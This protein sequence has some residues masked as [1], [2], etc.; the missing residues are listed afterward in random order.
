M[1]EVQ[2]PEAI[3]RRLAKLYGHELPDGPPTYPSGVAIAGRLRLLSGDTDAL[4][5]EAESISKLVMPFIANPSIIPD[6]APCLATGCFALD[7]VSATG[8][9]RVIDFAR[10][11]ADRFIADPDVR[12]ED[13]YFA[14]SLLGQA[15]TMTGESRY[16]DALMDLLLSA[17]T[18]QP[19]GLYWHCH[20][21]PWFWGR[22]NA[23]AALGIAEALTHVK[24][25]RRLE[26]L[27]ERHVTHLTAMAKL[28][29]ESGLWHQVINDPSTYIEH[30]ATTM[31]GTAIA[32]G[33]RHG[34]LARDTWQPVVDR[35]WS[36]SA[37]RIGKLGELEQVCVGTGPL[38]TLKDYAE[39]PFSNDRDERGGAMMLQFAVELMGF[40]DEP[41]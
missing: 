41:E 14:G 19:N 16:A 8:D 29:H 15:H 31:I 35:A 2:T 13:F 38:Q 20:A 24:D 40:S 1:H 30:S 11:L 10:N 23:F 18:L 3:A 28:Q 36:G 39:R 25:H 17:D 26:Q 9:E 34:W 33:M 4:K 7:L 21:S 12:V 37:A 5:A 22:G 32:R 6:A 27:I